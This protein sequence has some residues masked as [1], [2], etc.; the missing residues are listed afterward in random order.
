[1]SGF[2]GMLSGSFT[3]YQ[4]VSACRSTDQYELAVE[5]KM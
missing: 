1:M 2:L 4:G 3:S 5:R